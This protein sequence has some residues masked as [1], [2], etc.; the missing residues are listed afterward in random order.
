MRFSIIVIELVS[1]N[2]FVVVIRRMCKCAATVH[3]TDRPHARHVGTQLLV[4][5]DVT[6]LIRLYAGLV[7]CQVIGIRD[8]ADRDQCA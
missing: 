6:K 1:G 7:Q 8:A 2:D 4:D 5:I 3:I